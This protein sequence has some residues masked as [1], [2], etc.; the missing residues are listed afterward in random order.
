[1]NRSEV[2]HHRLSALSIVI[3]IA[4][5]EFKDN[6]RNRWLWMMAGILLL[7][8]L[9]V[10]FMGS[11]VSGNLVVF[12]PAQI[13]S[14]LV[15]LSVF[16]LPLGA[17]LLSYDSFV[18]EKESGTLLLLLTYPLARWHL[19][20][21]KFLGHACVMTI[22]C[23]LGFGLTGLILI[24]LGDTQTQLSI[25]IGFTHLIMS[26]ILL[27]LVF[28]LLGYWV[29]LCVR[30]KAKA[31]GILLILWFVLVLV[32][33]LILLSAVVGMSEM[34]N[35]TVLNLLILFNPTDLFRALNLLAAPSDT[36][37][38][39]SSLTLLAQTGLGLPLMYGLL[40]G[41]IGAL[42]LCCSWIFKYQEI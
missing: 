1:M 8:S 34:F 17:I 38:A 30:E 16:M 6:L 21:G 40:G 29:S 11:A 23:I 18:G 4:A 9:C 15:T 5:K 27:S 32:Y 28:V 7:L 35:R 36:L 2:L 14:G 39:K 37:A 19:V 10:G 12:E 20:C 13:L 3:T 31:L 26:S 25:A 42:L 33:D 24:S 41:W 22:A